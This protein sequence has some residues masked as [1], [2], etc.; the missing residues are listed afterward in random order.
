MFGVTEAQL[1]A[2]LNPLLWPFVRTLALFLENRTRLTPAL[3]L[4]TGLRHDRI[5]LTGTN[6]RAVTATNP[7]HFKRRYQPTTG[8][9]G[10]VYDLSPQANVYAQYSTAADPPAGVLSTASFAQV[11]DF[12]L[13]TGRQFEVG[14]K[15]DYLDGRGTAT[16]A[17]YHITRRNFA[18]SDPNNP[19]ATLPVGQQ[20][21]KGIELARKIEDTVLW[22]PTTGFPGLEGTPNKW[23]RSGEPKST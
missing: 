20:T 7:D 18:V 19:G 6:H 12:D 5:T 17:L 9:V 15:F 21:S 23:V 2:W 14:S 10:L 13:T 8:R 4:I 1:L 3:S 16:L 22:R 11:R